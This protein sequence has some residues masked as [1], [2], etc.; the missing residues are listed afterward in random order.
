MCFLYLVLLG[1]LASVDCGCNMARTIEFSAITVPNEFKFIAIQFASR[2]PAVWPEV[3][4]TWCV[5]EF[6]KL[7]SQQRV[8]AIHIPNHH[9]P[10]LHVASSPAI[11]AIGGWMKCSLA[12]I[13]DCFS[14]SHSLCST[15]KY[16]I[17]FNNR[18]KLNIYGFFFVLHWFMKLLF[19]D[20]F[21][22][23][24]LH[25]T[26]RNILFYFYRNLGGRKW[27]RFSIRLDHFWRMSEPGSCP[28]QLE[29]SDN[30]KPM[31]S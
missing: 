5:C 21:G 19:Y 3:A 29:D 20:F 13:Y 1:T 11:P 4:S 7:P 25:K 17:H 15:A 23:D 14:S 18:I 26:L 24:T 16:S 10:R 6:R 30:C 27:K 22:L 31:E 12:Q 2:W 28:G 9:D 8:T